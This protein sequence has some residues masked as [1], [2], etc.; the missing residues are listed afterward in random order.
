M[1]LHVYMHVQV[2]DLIAHLYQKFDTDCSQVIQALKIVFLDSSD[3]YGRITIYRLD[4]MG[5]IL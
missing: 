2:A 1:M 5:K 3:F 4:V